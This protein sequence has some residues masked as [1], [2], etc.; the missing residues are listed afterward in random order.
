MVFITQPPP[1]S[2][3]CQVAVQFADI[4]IMH[5]LE[6]RQAYISCEEYMSR[7]GTGRWVYK[8]GKL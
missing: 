4:H 5:S 8:K 7:K 2:A 3:F 1:T 6:Q